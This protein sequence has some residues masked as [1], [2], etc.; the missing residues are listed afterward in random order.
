MHNADLPQDSDL[1]VR[2]DI[3]KPGLRLSHEGSH[4]SRGVYQQVAQGLPDTGAT[5]LSAKQ[6]LSLEVALAQFLGGGSIRHRCPGQK[7]P[8]F[9]FQLPAGHPLAQRGG[10]VPLHLCPWGGAEGRLP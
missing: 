8:V 5:D 7:P 4:V 9:A 10:R 3:L 1:T 6:S 2:W